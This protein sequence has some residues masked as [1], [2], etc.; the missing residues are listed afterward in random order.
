[1]LDC[2]EGLS[3]E[4]LLLLNCGAGED[5]GEFLELQ[6]DQTSLKETK[7]TQP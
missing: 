2:K 4:E 1:M 7:G 5:S 3:T 6:G